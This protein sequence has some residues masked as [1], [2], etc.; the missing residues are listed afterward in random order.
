[1]LV[2]AWRRYT[3]APA[4]WGFYLLDRAAKLAEVDD[5]TIWRDI[6]VRPPQVWQ[7]KRGR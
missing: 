4:L 5:R 2:R 6:D 7:R 3:E 1:M